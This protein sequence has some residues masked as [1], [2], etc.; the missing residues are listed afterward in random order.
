MPNFSYLDTD[1]ECPRCHKMFPYSVAFQWGFSH[2]R[3]YDESHAYHLGDALVWKKLANG[4]VPAWTYFKEADRGITANLGAVRYRHLAVADHWY[5]GEG[6]SRLAP[7]VCPLCQQVL[8]STAVEIKDNIL[9]RAWI[10]ERGDFAEECSYYLVDENGNLSPM[11]LW[12]DVSMPTIEMSHGCQFDADS[13]K[14][15]GD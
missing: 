11:P 7:W 15:S 12:E 8:W 1:L 5:H 6:S 10:F 4:D 9:V 13:A 3:Y 2:W 14:A